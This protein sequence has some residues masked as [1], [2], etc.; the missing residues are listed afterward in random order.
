MS[1]IP[2]AMIKVHKTDSFITVLPTL[3]GN[4]SIVFARKETPED[5]DIPERQPNGEYPGYRWREDG[6]VHTCLTLSKEATFGLA[7]LLLDLV[8]RVSDGKD[9]DEVWA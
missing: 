5:S 2:G 6:E 1:M 4:Y 8:E 3:A 7:K 9:P